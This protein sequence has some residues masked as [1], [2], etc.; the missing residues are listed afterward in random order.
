M[1]EATGATVWGAA[2]DA[3]RLP[4]LDRALAPGDV[5]DLGAA[6]GEV[7]DVSGHTVGHVAY[8]FDGIAFTGDSLMAGGCGRLFEG[9]PDQMHASLLRLAGLDGATLVASGHEYT[10]TNLAFAATLEPDNADIT[11]RRTEVE[12]GL[13]HGRPSVPS[14]LDIERRTNPFL[15]CH[16]PA[17]KS[18][19]GTREATDAETFAAAR[20]AKDAF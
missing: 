15:R 18:A 2:A 4:A 9:T 1:R 17:V 7:V 16:L 6:R 14:A 13:S 3:H 5:V 19:T 12:D 8:L 11:S 20:A 10:L